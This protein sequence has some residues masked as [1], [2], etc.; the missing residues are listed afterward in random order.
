MS[1]TGERGGAPTKVGVAIVDVTTG[2]YACNAI[3]A[4]LFARERTGQGQHLDIALFD[5]QIALLANVGC[6]YLCSGEVPQRWG[7]AHSSIVPYQAFQA[8]DAY[9][10]LAIGNDRQW[11]R[12]CEAA[13]V[14]LWGCD[15]RFG[16]NP[17]RVANRVALIPM[18]EDLFRQKTV[19]EWLQLCADADV[20]AGTGARYASRNATSHGKHCACRR[21]AD[22]HL[23]NAGADASLATTSWAT[24]RRNS[25]RHIRTR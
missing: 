22:Q 21:H 7:N 23:N 19:V 9:L 20:R 1:I 12:F 25:C 17:Q 24:Y 4:A 15:E 11:S 14:A 6:N 10:V 16:T 8:A 3:L 13:G 5:S 18:L 2:M